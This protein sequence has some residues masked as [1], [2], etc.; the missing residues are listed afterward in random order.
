MSAQPFAG[1]TEQIPILVRDATGTLV[2][3]TTLVVTVARPGAAA[4]TYTYGVDAN[5][6]RSA[7]GTFALVFDPALGVAA[8]YSI[9]VTT[10]LTGGALTLTGVDRVQFSTVAP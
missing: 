3:P 4:V 1:A 5:V 9:T 7:V 2:D 10:T 8:M 6:T